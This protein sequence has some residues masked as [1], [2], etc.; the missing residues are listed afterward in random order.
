MPVKAIVISQQLLIATI[1][2][3]GS[4]SLL[5]SIDIIYSSL[6][7]YILMITDIVSAKILIW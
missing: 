4:V 1:L 6:H 3:T 7:K 2:Q 5:F